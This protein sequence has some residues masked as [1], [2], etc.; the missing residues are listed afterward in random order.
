M[1]YTISPELQLS[2]M[3][4]NTFIARLNDGR[5][6]Q[7]SYHLHI[8]LKGLESPRSSDELLK[9]LQQNLSDF[10]E[11]EDELIELLQ[12][13]LIPQ[14]LVIDSSNLTSS[15]VLPLSEQ[16]IHQSVM[17]AVTDLHVHKDIIPASLLRPF[18]NVLSL[19]YAMP[20]IFLLL[21]GIVAVQIATLDDIT[22][23]SSYSLHLEHVGI[24]IAFLIGS[25]FIHELGHMSA[26][27]KYGI[28]HGAMGV[29]LYF[30]VPIFYADVNEAWKLPR[31]RRIVVNLGGMYFQLLLTVPILLIFQNTGD[32]LYLWLIGLTYVTILLNLNPMLKLDGYWFVMDLFGVVNLHRRS[33]DAIQYAVNCVLSAIGLRH[34]RPHTPLF[35]ANLSRFQRV[36]LLVYIILSAGLAVIFLRISIPILYSQLYFAPYVIRGTFNHW[37]ILTFEML[38]EAGAYL[39]VPTLIV[40]NLLILVIRLVRTVSAKVLVKEDGLA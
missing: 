24:F 26:C 38:L 28:E 5:Q 17:E 19:F 11:T 40:I 4:G 21:I 22:L 34:N 10:D 12:D 3:D 8:L 39:I 16:A 30:F 14:G 25:T 20:V 35:L 36:A 27:R 7:L 31:W 29:G 32:A 33:N 18:T 15:A 9:Y 2:V 23:M 1:M 6:L 37:D 13:L